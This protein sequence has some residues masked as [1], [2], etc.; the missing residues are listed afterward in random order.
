MDLIGSASL[1]LL[2]WLKNYK[3]DWEYVWSITKYCYRYITYEIT[4]WCLD[5]I[6][7]TRHYHYNT[8]DDKP[9][10][11]YDDRELESQ[12]YDDIVHTINTEFESAFVKDIIDI[13][14]EEEKKIIQKIY[15]D[16][17][18]QKDIAEELGVSEW[19]ISVKKQRALDKI[20]IFYLQYEEAVQLGI[21]LHYT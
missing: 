9:H 12:V 8:E 20:R 19:N 11:I 15:F 1:W 2:Q 5:I 13:L 7:S 14:K 21:D 16:W 6:G 10:I 3:T 17:V 4:K 18:S